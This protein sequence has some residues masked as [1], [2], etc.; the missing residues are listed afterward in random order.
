MAR[1]MLCVHALYAC[2]EYIVEVSVKVLV[3]NVGSTSFKYQLLEMDTETVLAAGR[4]ERVN[5]PKAFISHKAKGGQ[6]EFTRELGQADYA[7]CIDAVI[8]YLL[9]KEIGVISRLDEITAVGFK[10]VHAGE[11]YGPCFL[12][13]KVM[14]AME[15]YTPVVPLHNPAYINA[16][17]VFAKLMPGIP[18][19]GLMETAFHQQMPEYARVYSLPYRWYEEYGVRRYGFH[20]ASHR[21]VAER[22]P[23]LLGRPASELKVVSCHLGGTASLT[24]VKHGVS[25]DNSLGFGAQDGIPHSTRPGCFDGFILLYIMEKEGLS[26]QQMRQIL[27]KESGL[28]GISGVSGD[29]RDLEEAAAAGNKRAQLA[30]DIFCYEVKKHIGAYA[31]A[32][33]GLDAIAFAGGIGERGVN[34]RRRVCEGL[35]FLGAILDPERNAAHR[36]TEGIVSTDDSRV[37]ILVVPTNEE[38]IV[39]RET[40][41]LLRSQE[42]TA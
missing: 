27:Q 18:L 1:R 4:A 35:E 37:K 17:R 12:D 25:I 7:A 8:G 13:D 30:L 23:Q 3:A 20:G 40:V 9:D 19:V 6:V 16:I 34:I 31:A 15:A 11:I 33:G 22:V 14:A 38:L 21:Y 24:A 26:V 2:S 42:R 41:R 29:V 39:A 36:G 10:T 28:L 32:M 5:S